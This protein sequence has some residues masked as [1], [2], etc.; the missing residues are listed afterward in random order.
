MFPFDS[1]D[2]LEGT[3]CFSI[4]LNLSS[5]A[6]KSSAKILHRGKTKGFLIN[7]RYIDRHNNILDIDPL[8]AKSR[9]RPQHHQHRTPQGDHFQRTARAA[10][11]G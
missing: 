4:K 10:V 5:A 7:L 3:L 9:S 1:K 2:V 6:A 11:T 8:G